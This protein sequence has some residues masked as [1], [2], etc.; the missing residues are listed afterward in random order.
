MKAYKDLSLSP[1]VPWSST[2]HRTVCSWGSRPSCRVLLPGHTT[3]SERHGNH[4]LGSIEGRWDS[5]HVGLTHTGAVGKWS[6]WPPLPQGTVHSL[7]HYILITFLRSKNNIPV[8]AKCD[9][10]TC[11]NSC[12][13]FCGFEK[14]DTARAKL[15]Q[16]Q[17]LRCWDLMFA[18]YTP[19]DFL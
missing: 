13:F 5:S 15:L 1:H 3:C 16:A 11:N 17:G 2:E 4:H 19:T 10:S 7:R 8:F 12:G 9:R 6:S 18:C 14:R